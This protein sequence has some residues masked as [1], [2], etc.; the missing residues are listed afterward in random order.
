MAEPLQPVD[1][2]TRLR[3]LPKVD[4]HRHLE[5]A[6]RPETLWEFHLARGEHRH[7]SLAALREAF[8][9]PP[10]AAPGFLGFLDRF[11]ALRFHYGGPAEI[12]RL[13]REAV[14]DAADDGVVHLELRFSPVFL[15][16]RQLPYAENAPPPPLEL[17][18][19]AAEA[20]VRGARGEAARRGVSLV[21]I[22]C[23]GR[24]AGVAGN[25][26]SAELLA[27]PIGASFVAV[28]L[29][30]DEQI[31]VADFEELLAPWREAGRAVTLHAGED[32]RGD[33]AAR[34]REAVLRHG[35][36]RIGHGVRAIEDP[37]TVELLRARGVPL[38]TCLTS[39]VQTRA[40]P[41]FAAHPVGAL[42]RAGVHVTLNSDDPVV[43]GITLSEDYA[44]AHERT[45]L[46][47]DELR[48]LA[49]NGA[50]AAFLPAAEREALAQRIAA[51]W[52]RALR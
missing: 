51:A 34:V 15:A 22:L 11:P 4:L 40:A 21:F 12:E 49:V 16:A 31:P 30:G 20:L 28:D 38:E 37:A 36:A 35:A 7:A 45:G 48:R 44:R 47:L 26:P 5:G 43:S 33:G 17:A 39:N 2:R 24:H 32:L 50:R 19:A 52:D 13:G 10:G 3:A 25:H 27:R 1:L 14:A 9:I 8:I 46:S 18:E 42:L 29:A 6:M 23:L 41:S